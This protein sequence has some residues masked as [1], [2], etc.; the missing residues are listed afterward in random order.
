MP[1]T[2]RAFGGLKRK[3]HLSKAALLEE[4]LAIP[5]KSPRRCAAYFFPFFATV[6]IAYGFAG[7]QA[8]LSPRFTTT[9]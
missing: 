4:I 1:A 9:A 8:L 5:L 6:I 2:A 7:R 3:G